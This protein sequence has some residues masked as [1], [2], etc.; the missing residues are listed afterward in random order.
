MIRG[1]FLV[2]FVRDSAGELVIVVAGDQNWR[3]LRDAIAALAG[4]KS[5]EAQGRADEAE[6]RK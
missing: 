2:H 3:T 4:V 6:S 1:V 5:V